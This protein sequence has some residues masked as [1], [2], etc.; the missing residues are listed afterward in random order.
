[1]LD[2][3]KSLEERWRI[4]HPYWEKEKN[5]GYGQYVRISVKGLFGTDKNK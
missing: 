1:M 4:F 3:N 5:T 2:N